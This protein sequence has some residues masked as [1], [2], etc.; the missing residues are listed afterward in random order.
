[1][2]VAKKYINLLRPTYVGMQCDIQD[3]TVGVLSTLEAQPANH[4]GNSGPRGLPWRSVHFD[5]Q[6]I[7]DIHNGSAWSW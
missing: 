2:R 3:S 7:R 4:T 1:M 5:L 6:L